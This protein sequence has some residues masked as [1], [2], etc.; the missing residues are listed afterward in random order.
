MTEDSKYI[1]CNIKP[2]KSAENAKPY[3]LRM[4]I[5]NTS[6]LDAGLPIF[7]KPSIEFTY[8]YVNVSQFNDVPV[9]DSTPKPNKDAYLGKVPI[10]AICVSVSIF[11]IIIAGL[12]LYARLKTSFGKA[13]ISGESYKVY[14]RDPSRTNRLT[15]GVKDGATNTSTNKGIIRILIFLSID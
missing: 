1:R 5:H 3:L 8:F 12:L 6:K 15:T 13:K 2:E 9:I 14:T 7:Y 10:I 4:E 11:L